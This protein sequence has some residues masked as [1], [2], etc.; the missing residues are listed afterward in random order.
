MDSFDDEDY[1]GY[2]SNEGS[3]S[4][5]LYGACSTINIDHIGEKRRVP[6][7]VLKIPTQQVIKK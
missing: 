2:S 3:L 4:P 5:S 1:K 6:T 7:M